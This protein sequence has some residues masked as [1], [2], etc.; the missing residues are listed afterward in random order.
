M[1]YSPQELLGQFHEVDIAALFNPDIPTKKERTEKIKIA[2]QKIRL[3]KS[4]TKEEQD[5]IKARWDGRKV[6]HAQQEKLHLAPYTLILDVISQIEIFISE[7]AA[8]KAKDPIPEPPNFNKE[9]HAVIFG[10]IQEGQW[11]IGS[12][13]D[14]KKWE[15]KRTIDNA[16]ETGRIFQQQVKD[17][18]QRIKAIPSRVIGYVILVVFTTM[19]AVWFLYTVTSSDLY[20]FTNEG[21]LYSIGG[22]LAVF[23]LCI[24][25]IFTLLNERKKLENLIPEIQEKIKQTKVIYIKAKKILQSLDD[26]E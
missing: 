16:R 21:T 11:K 18:K 23:A 26:I 1:T 14:A 25:Q 22:F 10:D 17:A 12:V 15:V 5:T 3:I 6:G 20:D 24:Y 8:L 4:R 9:S 2:R 13:I 19:L 7:L